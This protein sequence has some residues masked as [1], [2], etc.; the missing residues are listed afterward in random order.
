MTLGPSPLLEMVGPQRSLR[1]FEIISIF[2]RTV[3]VGLTITQRSVDTLYPIATSRWKLT[4]GYH[5]QRVTSGVD[6]SWQPYRKMREGSTSVDALLCIYLI[7]LENS[8]VAP[9]ALHEHVPVQDILQHSS[10]F[11]ASC[12]DF[13]RG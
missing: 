3:A 10:S 5:A 8:H 12:T 4:D 1:V 13:V 6:N 7:G 11:R 9:T 2:L